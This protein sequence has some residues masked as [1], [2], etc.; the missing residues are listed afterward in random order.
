MA[1]CVAKL[2]C[3][4]HK[5]ILG[6]GRGTLSGKHNL[7]LPAMWHLYGMPLF[8][9]QP[10]EALPGSLGCLVLV[11]KKVLNGLEV[12]GRPRR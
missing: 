12:A 10:G 2:Y 3:V 4:I 1:D 8:R 7:C 6:P 11:V 9:R 5:W